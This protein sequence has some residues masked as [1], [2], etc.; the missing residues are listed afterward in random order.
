METQIHVPVG[1]PV[2]RK[3]H[4]FV[5]EHNVTEGALQLLKELRPSWEPSSVNTKV[6]LPPN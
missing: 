3:I 5:D 2:I 6:K 1:S 4:V